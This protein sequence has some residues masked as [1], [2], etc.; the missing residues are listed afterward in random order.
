M[1]AV[2]KG[3]KM[4]EIKGCSHCTSWKHQNG[5]R[6]CPRGR[7]SCTVLEGGIKCD[8]DHD[9]SLHGSGS[10]YCMTASVVSLAAE[11][12]AKK[13]DVFAPVLLEI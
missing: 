13:G 7:A 8:K 4:E 9:A 11:D 12:N 6:M 1:T 5:K 3:K 2:E 10:R